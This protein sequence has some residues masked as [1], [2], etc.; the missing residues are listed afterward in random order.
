MKAY[1]VFDADGSFL[2]V[3]Y[4]DFF[5]RSS[6]QSGAWMTS[7]RESGVTLQGETRRPHVSVTM[8]FSK[9]TPS[10]P[11][12]LT[13]DELETF[14]HE[15]GHALHGIF[16]DTHYPALSGTNV[17][18]DFVE[19]PSQFMENFALRPEFLRTFA[20]HYETGEEMPETLL[21][22]IRRAHNFNAAYACIRQVSFGLL[23]MALLYAHRKARRRHSQLRTRGLEVGTVDAVCARNL[24]VCAVRTHYERRLFRRILQL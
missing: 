21:E 16:A 5:P 12:L 10:R 22:R 8:N 7:Y 20:H 11:S 13:F 1:E 24:H 9:P 17:Y 23:D 2:A 6:K 4:T 18:W 14:L 19:L 3:L 15:F